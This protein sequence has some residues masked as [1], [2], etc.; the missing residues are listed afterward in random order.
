MRSHASVTATF[1]KKKE[2]S[3]KL[4]S[5]VLIFVSPHPSC[6]VRLQRVC[7]GQFFLS[8]EPFF[9]SCF[10]GQPALVV[11]SADVTGLKNMESKAVLMHKN[12]DKPDES[13]SPP[14]AKIEI[15]HL[16]KTKVSRATA[17]P[18]WKWSKDI[19]PT[20]K[21]DT[22]QVP[23]VGYVISGSI[24]IAF[25]DKQETIRAGEVYEIPAGHDAWVEGNQEAVMIDFAPQMATDW[26]KEGHAHAH[27]QH[28]YEP[29]RRDVNTSVK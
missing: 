9:F 25:G 18:G 11:A 7:G 17:R 22:C 23:H 2:G 15:V 16:G 13:R 8:P 10:S 19:K 26:G 6:M 21:T 27:G 1:R 5:R 29:G 12:F 20:A 28:G 3:L 24:V 14:N 4:L